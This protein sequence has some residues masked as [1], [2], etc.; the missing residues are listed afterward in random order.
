M[1]ANEL[2]QVGMNELVVS[3]SLGHASQSITYG[4]Y[5]KESRVEILMKEISKIQIKIIR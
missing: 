5:S 2:K 1:F 4:R 3:E